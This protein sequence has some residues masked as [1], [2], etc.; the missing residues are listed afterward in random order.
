MTKVK[1]DI[2]SEVYKDTQKNWNLTLMGKKAEIQ[3]NWYD[4]LMSCVLHFAKISASCLASSF[5]SIENGSS[6]KFTL[7]YLF[8]TM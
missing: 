2:E 6:L 4:V 5:V 1:F 8:C 3:V 7:S